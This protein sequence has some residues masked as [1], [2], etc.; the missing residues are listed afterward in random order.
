MWLDE[1]RKAFVAKAVPRSAP[2]HGRTMRDF[3]NHSV[4]VMQIGLGTYGTFLQA[5]V[6]WV[7]VLLRATTYDDSQSLRGIGVDPVEEIV[8]PL[9]TLSLRNSKSLSASVVCGAVVEDFQRSTIRVFCLPENARRTFRKKM[10]K[11]KV[12]RRLWKDVDKN[13]AYLEN[14]S[15]V[16]TPHPEFESQ[17]A[18][19]QQQAGVY[20]NLLEERVVPCYT[21]GKVLKMHSAKECEVLIV[22]AEGADCAILRSMLA[23]CQTQ[24]CPWPRV[25]RFETWGWD[26]EEARLSECSECKEEEA[27]IQTLQQEEYL[28]VQA[29]RDATLLHGPAVRR[30][31]ALAAWADQHFLLTCYVCEYKLWPSKPSFAKEVGKG[32]S[33]WG[34]VLKNHKRRLQ[35]NL[36]TQWLHQSNWCCRGCLNEQQKKGSVARTLKEGRMNKVALQLATLRSYIALRDKK[37][38]ALSD[39]LA[40]FHGLHI[41]SSI[42][43]KIKSRNRE[44]ILHVFGR[45]YKCFTKFLLN[46]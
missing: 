29:C 7:R 32:R 46:T 43:S 14:M 30:S 10:D 20:D 11:A 13:L 6:P 4:H 33:Q 31:E 37:T 35:Q 26:D 1:K 8:R 18:W 45:D 34:S 15:A 28:L 22:D 2:Y 9:E 5:D 27:V 16:G 25:I 40:R 24:Q 3:A 17:A 41:E 44:L 19:V 12:K 38:D 36:K 21:F 23:C 39:S 42:Q